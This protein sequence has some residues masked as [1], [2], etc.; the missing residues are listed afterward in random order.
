MSNPYGWATPTGDGQQAVY[1][2]RPGENIAIGTPDQVYGGQPYAVQDAPYD[3]GYQQYLSFSSQYPQDTYAHD[4]FATPI[5]GSRPTFIKYL[6]ERPSVSIVDATTL[7]IRNW[8]NFTGRA[9]PSE[10]WGVRI[11]LL[12]L[13]VLWW[14]VVLAIA[15]MGEL[16]PDDPFTQTLVAGIALVTIASTVLLAVPTLSLTVRRFHDT[17]HSGWNYLLFYVPFA[18]FMASYY[19]A[20]RSDSDGWRF[21]DITRPLYGVDDLT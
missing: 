11:I 1:F 21:D 17:N 4:P 7:W 18:S 14:V 10:Y 15:Q 5:R 9:S 16:T 20:R 3:N 12:L 6:G 19:L 8:R 2:A 13:R